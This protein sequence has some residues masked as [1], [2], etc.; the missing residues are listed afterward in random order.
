[1]I[2]GSIRA[3]LTAAERTITSALWRNR[4]FLFIVG[5]HMLTGAVICSIYRIPFWAPLLE[6]LVTILSMIL[7]FT[8]VCAAG[9][10]VWRFIY[11]L[12]RVRP[13]KPIHWM[14]SDIR[15]YLSRYVRLVDGTICF[16][17]LAALAN[18]FTLLKNLVSNFVPFSLDP[19]FAELDRILHG[20]VDVWTLLWPVFG[21][22]FITT[23][24]NVAYH[25]WFVLIY[26]MAFV[27]AYDQRD[28]ERGMTYL[29]AFALT[30]IIGGNVLATLFSSVGPVYFE[31]FG[32]GD[33]FTE[34]LLKLEMLNE[35]SPVW[36]LSV[37]DLLLTNYNTEG[38]IRGISA[39]PSMHVA[40]SVL[41]ALFAFR[42]SRWLGWAF[43]VFAVVIQ[44]G[45]V[46][47]AWHY[48]VDGYFGALVALVCWYVAQFLA[49]KFYLRSVGFQ[50]AS[51]AT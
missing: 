18:T 35:I 34:Q 37:H 36:A 13:K 26:A 45:S 22:P 48:A 51:L 16:V 6:N 41:M 27:A 10:M 12:F 47:L 8:I 46:H 28:P 24:I 17:A 49:K 38:M 4:L 3:S 2:Y 30:F 50:S 21:Y 32:F 7:N 29:V 15:T 25:L 19:T 40:S 9:F 44:I 39:M 20:G 14:V 33:T 23:M 11:A 43:T 1:M 5:L 42:Y 31:E